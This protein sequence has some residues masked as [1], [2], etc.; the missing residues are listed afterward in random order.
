[1][2]VLARR[3]LTNRA[4]RDGT[5]KGITCQ[6]LAKILAN[7]V[8]VGIVEWNGVQYPGTHEWI[9]EPDTFR[10]VQELLCALRGATANAGTRTTR[11]VC[12]T[13]GCAAGARRSSTP[14]PNR[15][16]SSARAGR[17]T[18]QA[19][20]RS[21]RSRPK[22]SKPKSKSGTSA[23]SCRPCGAKGYA[24]RLRSSSQIA[25]APTPPR[26]GLATSGLTA[27]NRRRCWS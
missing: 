2:G 11:R 14:R 5:S 24:R 26:S 17:T 7:A 8:Y 9:V 13:A 10:G 15:P 3:R 18:P 6:S 1:M 19:P 21:A 16:T 4:R 22:I 12:C 23:S 20:G 27:A 25:D